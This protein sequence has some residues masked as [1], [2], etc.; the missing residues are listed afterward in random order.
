M[1]HTRQIIFSLLSIYLLVLMVLPCSESHLEPDIR[2]NLSAKTGHG[3]DNEHGHDV[4]LCTP[5]CVCGS[6]LVAITLQSAI[7]F[8][9]LQADVI[10]RRD[11]SNFYQSV[12]SSFYGS[13]WQ[14]PRLK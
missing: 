3:H 13:I 10:Y 5:F 8:D 4:E 1:K 11:L 12:E 2:K 6:C 9:I 7:D 14:P